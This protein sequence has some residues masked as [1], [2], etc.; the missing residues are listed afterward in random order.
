MMY[1]IT[2]NTLEKVLEALS[3]NWFSDDGE[4]NKDDIIE[5]QELLEHELKLQGWE[6]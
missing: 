4:F 2:K 3:N 1:E 6:K 5:A